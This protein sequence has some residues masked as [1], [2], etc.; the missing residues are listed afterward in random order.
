[1]SKATKPK[2]Q[3]RLTFSLEEKEKELL[4][5]ILMNGGRISE[6]R[7]K[8]IYLEKYS[9]WEL[10]KAEKKLAKKGFLLIKGHKKN[11]EGLS[12]EV[13]QDAFEALYGQFL[14]KTTQP[15]KDKTPEFIPNA[16]CGEFSILWYLWSL[17][18]LFNI[19]LFSPKSRK[20]IHR[21][22]EKKAAESL[23]LSREGA[24]FLI[25]LLKGLPNSTSLIDKGYKKYSAMLNSPHSV[26]KEVY[27]I[28]Y[29]RLR[30]SSEL[31]P[32]DVGKD[33]MDYLLEELA[34]LEIGDWYS[35]ED[36][37]SNARGT[38]FSCNQPFRWIHFHEESIWN[39]L[40]QKL[41]LLGIVNTAIN[42]DKK[43]FLSLT[44]LGS[45]CLDRIS[46]EDFASELSERRGKFLVHPNFEITT[47]S[48]EIHP[49]VM[50]ELAMFAHTVKSDTA[51][52][53]KITR[54]S[55][56]QGKRLGLSTAKM[57]SFLNENSRGKIPQ[58]VEYS[59]K[60][61]GE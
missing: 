26:V 61:W 35:L 1:M 28:A 11:G 25:I 57:T 41:G 59:I 5:L 20:R 19:Y 7:L 42:N 22:S 2:K 15:S 13:P 50:L 14:S 24:R 55:V 44:K 36:F 39:I 37:V 16:C 34:S 30:E 47:V 33:N 9:F 45:Y 21:A 58:N 31:G 40:S 27:R 4:S 17:D 48:K 32:K 29:Y 12:Y 52:V 46:E 8:K 56:N 53:F 43:R 3:N 10:Q 49:K 51:S 18:S 6:T 38:L 54:E 60:D 23:A